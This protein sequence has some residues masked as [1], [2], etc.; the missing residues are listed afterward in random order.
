VNSFSTHQHQINTPKQIGSLTTHIKDH[1]SMIPIRVLSNL[2]GSLYRVLRFFSFSFAFH[3]SIR[4][5]SAQSS[6]LLF[7]CGSGKVVI[8]LDQIK[9]TCYDIK[10]EVF[11]DAIAQIDLEGKPEWANVDFSTL[12]T[13]PIRLGK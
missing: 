11:Y 9:K 10:M 12:P 4:I 6:L 5:T 7:F 2:Y 8:L 13:K 1:V 3:Q